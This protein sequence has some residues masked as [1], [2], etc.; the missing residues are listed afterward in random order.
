MTAWLDWGGG[1]QQAVLPSS[2]LS[3]S[4]VKTLSSLPPSPSSLRLPHPPHLPSPVPPLKA[5][6]L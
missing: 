6:L 1:S 2:R 3:D 4:S 5:A